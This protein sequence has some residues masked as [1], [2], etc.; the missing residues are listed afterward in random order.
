MSYSPTT[1]FTTGDLVASQL[2]VNQQGARDYINNDIEQGDIQTGSYDTADIQPGWP[3]LANDDYRFTTGGVSIIRET[4]DVATAR[5]Y[6]TATIKTQD[7]T[8]QVVYQDIPGAGRR[9][10]LEDI[11]DVVV[12][13]MAYAEGLI[14]GD[15]AYRNLVSPTPYKVDS[16]FYLSIDGVIE[17]RTVC[18]IFLESG[19][20]AASTQSV[21]SGGLNQGDFE[22]L[23]RP[24]YIF[25]AQANFTPGWHTIK[26][27]CDPRS[28]SLFVNSIS[29]QIEVLSRGGRTDW[30]GTNF[31]TL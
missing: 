16:R 30:T 31:L 2:T 11:G 20:T 29:M 3:V 25:W 28:P 18:Y 27:V 5:K 9:F 13:L 8:Q 24:L 10:F 7:P 6:V 15:Y 19:P 1:T 14:D 12:E 23:R 17:P 26:L 22:A 4:T 21:M